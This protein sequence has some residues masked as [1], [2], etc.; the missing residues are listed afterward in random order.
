MKSPTVI[1]PIGLLADS[2]GRRINLS[3][4][5][6]QP[7]TYTGQR[8]YTLASIGACMN[9]GKTTTAANLIKGLV[10]SGLKVGAAKITGTGAVGDIYFMRDAGA[11]PVLDFTECGFPSTYRAT[12]EQVLGILETLTSHIAAAGVDAIVIEIADGLFQKETS[13]LAT[14]LSFSHAI[15]GL[16][17]SAPTALGAAGGV[18]WLQRYNL[19]VVA[20]GG[21]LTTSPLAAHEAE[22]VTGLPVLTLEQLRDPATLVSLGLQPKTAVSV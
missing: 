15:D 22:E 12:P 18:E 9:S 11:N 17:F 4:Y 2:E 21:M 10:N 5:A 19:P 13:K 6:L 14:S 1:N 20:I 3:N 7:I 8:P 16:I